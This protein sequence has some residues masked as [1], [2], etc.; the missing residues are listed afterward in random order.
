M[1]RSPQAAARELAEG[2]GVLLHLGSGQYHGINPVG[3]AIWELLDEPTTV[4]DVIDRL[5]D[6]VDDPPPSLESDV[7]RY[8]T[9]LHERDLVT[10]VER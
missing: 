4:A 5:R 2:E 7:L 9:A 3:L 10:T 1:Q 8:L 6:R